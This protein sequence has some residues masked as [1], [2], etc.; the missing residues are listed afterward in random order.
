MKFEIHRQDM[1]NGRVNKLTIEGDSLINAIKANFKKVVEVSSY[2]NVPVRYPVSATLAYK[3]EILGGQGGV[4]VTL[5][6]MHKEY[7]DKPAATRLHR[8][9]IHARREDIDAQSFEIRERAVQS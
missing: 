7:E 1:R 3:G 9:W 4:E 2:H 5:E 8:I 6:W